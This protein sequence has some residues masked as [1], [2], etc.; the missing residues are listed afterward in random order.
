MS[1]LIRFCQYSQL[2]LRGKPTT[3]PLLQV[4][5]WQDVIIGYLQLRFWHC[6]HS[7]LRGLKSMLTHR[8]GVWTEVDTQGTYIMKNSPGVSLKP[9]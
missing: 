3:S 5:A 4:S 9:M 2:V 1:T 8:P 6:L 7:S